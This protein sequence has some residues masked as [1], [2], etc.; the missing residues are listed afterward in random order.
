MLTFLRFL[1][2]TF[3]WLRLELAA[4]QEP[5]RPWII[6]RARGRWRVYYGESTGHALEELEAAHKEGE[7]PEAW[8]AIRQALEGVEPHKPLEFT[9]EAL[10]SAA[11]ELEAAQAEA[12]KAGLA[13]LEAERDRRRQ[14]LELARTQRAALEAELAELEEQARIDAQTTKRPLSGPELALEAEET[15]RR[16]AAELEAARKRE[17]G[18]VA[19]LG[20][21]VPG[22]P[23]VAS[24][25][26]D[27]E[28]IDRAR[29][30]F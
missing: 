15:A 23:V 2:W 3:Y 12:A 1:A 13:E 29:R 18:D 14:F 21:R 30:G 7:G 19:E 25:A 27:P 9:P 26:D 10:G 17:A 4:L 6:A 22:A 24:S 16:E 8:Q 5:A 28:D 11:D 20:D